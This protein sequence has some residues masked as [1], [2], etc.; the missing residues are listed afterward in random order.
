MMLPVESDHITLPYNLNT[1]TV[2]FADLDITH[3]ANADYS[4]NME[5]VNEVWTPVLHDNEAL[6]R[7]LKPGD[8]V[9]RVRYRL[10]GGTWGEP[11]P[12]LYLT[13]TPPLYLTWWAKLLYLL[14]S[15]ILLV[16]IFLFYKHKLDLEQKLSI[17]KENSRN[18]NVL[19]E[20]RLVFFTN[21]T[22]ELRTPLS[23][24]VG[25]IEDLVNDENL[26]QSQRKKL[27][28]IRASSMRLLNLI[29]GILEFRKTE[30]RNRKLEVVYG[31]LSNYVRE[32]GLRYKELNSKQNV[33]VVIDM[34]ENDEIFA[35]YDPEVVQTVV[36]NLMGNALKYTAEGVITLRLAIDDMHGV[37]YVRLSVADTGEGYG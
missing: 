36:N 17:E 33:S 25:P 30:T 10:N 11:E 2:A 29:N 19:N 37:E 5:G 8:Y 3:S 20:E 26:N 22:H 32:I 28:T 23:L 24:I 12:L 13:I 27:L 9:F 34:A 7:D 6:Y 31:N 15:I 21:I 1:F 35:Y 14:G 18:S 4:Y 16:F